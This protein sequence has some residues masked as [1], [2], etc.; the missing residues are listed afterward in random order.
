M[1]SVHIFDVDS[2]LGS[3]FIGGKKVIFDNPRGVVLIKVVKKP[4]NN[5]ICVFVGLFIILV[6]TSPPTK[7]CF[8][9]L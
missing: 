2:A 8:V 9:Q 3:W 7:A 6:R 5:G 1:D 4:D